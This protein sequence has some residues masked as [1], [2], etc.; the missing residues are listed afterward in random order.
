ML[1]TQDYNKFHWRI[2]RQIS[3]NI[4]KPTCTVKLANAVTWDYA[5]FCI[6]STRFHSVIGG[7]WHLELATYPIDELARLI[8]FLIQILKFL[9]FSQHIKLCTWNFK[10]ITL[11]A[12]LEE[13]AAFSKFLRFGFN[14]LRINL[15]LEAYII[16]CLLSL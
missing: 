5:K 8:Y 7:I 2:A 15:Y 11:V 12:L 14:N 1:I 16:S 4:L 6:H 10:F 3:C 9:P 13:W